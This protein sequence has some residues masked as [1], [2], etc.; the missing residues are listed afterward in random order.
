MTTS[1]LLLPGP[2]NLNEQSFSMTLTNPNPFPVA[3]SVSAPLFR[4]I[5]SISPSEG[6]VGGGGGQLKPITFKMKAI[7]DK[8]AKPTM[9]CLVEED[10]Y[11]RVQMIRAELLS[12]N[13]PVSALI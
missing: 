9:H 5:F 12:S 4:E 8:L 2:Y 13:E 11:Y 3:F 10:C 1:F 6:V 7:C